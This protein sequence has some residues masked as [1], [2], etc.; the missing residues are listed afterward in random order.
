[1]DKLDPRKVT[2]RTFSAFRFVCY[3]VLIPVSYYTG[4][5]HS[6]DFIAL[7]SIVALAESAGAMWRADVPNK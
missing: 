2:W 5:I 3:I 6:V 4:W 1:M 7:L